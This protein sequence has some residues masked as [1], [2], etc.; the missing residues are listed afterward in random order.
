[1]DQI[2]LKQANHDWEYFIDCLN[3]DE[4]KGLLD[5]AEPIGSNSLN[6]YSATND[7][8]RFDQTIN[9][10]SK[11]YL[12]DEEIILTVYNFYIERDLNEL[13]F[14]YVNKAEEYFHKNGKV[15]SSSI[16]NIINNLESTQLLSKYKI[17]LDR[18]RSLSPSNIPKITP[19][20][21]NDKRQLNKFILN[22]I[23]QVLR[24]IREKIEALRQVTHENRF[25]DF[26]QAILRFRFPI[27]GWSIH[28]QSRLG[29][30]AGGA[31]AGN[32]DL[33][34]QSGGG[35]YIALIEAFILRDKGYTQTHILKCPKYISTINKYYVVV[36]YLEK[37]KDF[38]SKWSSY[39]CDV[40]SILYPDS[41]SIDKN[42]GFV[43]IVDEFEDVNNFKIAKT[44]HNTNCELFHI[45]I[46]LTE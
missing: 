12:Y 15:I 37:S 17:S 10:L 21:V 38:E 45:M 8:L 1:M 41:F 18:I 40:L 39:K 33:V 22:E 34:I 23:I 35:K 2:L 44:N 26:M 32:A 7:T 16:Q 27:W 11:R 46:N 42:I 24:I 20:T 25:N 43:D 19:D 29:T 9:R 36:Y 30:S 4:K 14:D 5:L 28:D 13:A 31:D 6:Y 3:D